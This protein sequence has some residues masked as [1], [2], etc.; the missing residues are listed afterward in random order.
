MGNSIDKVIQELL[1]T[2]PDS[3]KLQERVAELPPGDV[4]DAAIKLHKGS[5]DLQ[6]QSVYKRVKKYGVRIVCLMCAWEGRHHPGDVRLRNRKCSQCG[7]QRL[8]PQWWIERYPSKAAAE[9]KRVR[10]TSFL[11]N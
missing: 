7:L 1:D 3:D 9:T 6:A 5:K 2:Y 4:V 10:E 8:R 11:L